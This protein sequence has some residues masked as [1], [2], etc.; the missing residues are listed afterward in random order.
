MSAE[1]EI[2]TDAEGE[3]L[4]EHEAELP[5]EAAVGAW[6]I[7]E[8]LS[9]FGVAPGPETERFADRVEALWAGGEEGDLEGEDGR[10]WRFVNDKLGD[11]GLIPLFSHGGER[12]R[13]AG[14]V[15]AGCDFI[16]HNATRLKRYVREKP[17]RIAEVAQI[18]RDQARI[19]LSAA[20]C[21][22]LSELN[23]IEPVLKT[24]S[25][26]RSPFSFG[27]GPRWTAVDLLEELMP[28]VSKLRAQVPEQSLTEEEQG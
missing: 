15:L 23:T 16:A 17:E 27:S 9:G 26:K 8:A 1:P 4:L 20:A 28:I 19:D 18:L 5:A 13:L 12:A 7:S 21:A 10:V 2:P 22:L 24:F 11:E 3:G 6:S 25:N 14:L